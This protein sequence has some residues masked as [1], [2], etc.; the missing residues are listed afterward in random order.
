MRTAARLALAVVWLAVALW[1]RP[2]EDRVGPAAEPLPPEVTFARVALGGLNGLLADF[3][4]L[5]AAQQQD[6]GQFFELVQT[7]RWIAALQPQLGRLYD[8]QAWNMAFNIS[9]QFHDPTDRWRWVQAGLR[10]LL[11]EGLT[12]DPA[13]EAIDESLA[14]IIGGKVADYLDPAHWEYKKRWAD[15][16]SWILRGD[17]VDPDVF[18][19]APTRAELLADPQV[20]ALLDAARPF[21]ADLLNDLYEVRGPRARPPAALAELLGRPEHA[22]ALARLTLYARLERLRRVWRMSLERLEWVDHEYGPFDWRAAQPHALYW[23]LSAAEK[24]GGRGQRK[25]V[26][27]LIYQTLWS[28]FERGRL[29]YRPGSD[30]IFPTPDIRL[31]PR[32][33]REYRRVMAYFPD[34][35]SL[36]ASFQIFQQDAL[37]ALYT[38]NRRTEARRRYAELQRRFPDASEYR[39]SFED[40]VFGCLVDRARGD[41]SEVTGVVEGLLVQA[42]HWYAADEDSRAAG[43]ESLAR[44]IYQRYAA[45]AG[46]S[47]APQL[48][49]FGELQA[50]TLE[51]CLGD[52]LAP[53]LRDRLKARLPALSERLR[54]AGEA[55][56]R[57]HE[58][59]RP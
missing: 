54:R 40:F 58:E 31:I 50:A 17:R 22:A 14:L 7:A 16:W 34:D 46:G 33:E 20:T 13:D 25:P 8:F 51:A 3:L 57:P 21:G 10:L 23:A 43:M 15:E 55:G 36:S 49:P 29:V 37:L 44:L 24:A 6:R 39:Q 1:L 59:A 35:P 11:D 19:A 9:V 45:T 30:L 28:A 48:P 5:R 56:E 27:R 18:A 32:V 38:F 12:N 47:A 4:W 26:E 52:A 2:A 41:V 42:W 53:A